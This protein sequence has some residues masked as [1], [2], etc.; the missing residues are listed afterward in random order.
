MDSAKEKLS[1]TRE[2]VFA[3]CE[4]SIE[5][6]VVPTVKL[7]KPLFVNL[8]ANR[9]SA[10]I[11]EWKEENAVRLNHSPSYWRNLAQ[12]L[13]TKCDE[14]QLEIDILKGRLNPPLESE[15]DA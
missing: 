2:N 6:G 4:V 13:I 14:L 12:G 1:V 10:Y 8:K 5:S 7:I 15:S 9:I 11:G 3:M